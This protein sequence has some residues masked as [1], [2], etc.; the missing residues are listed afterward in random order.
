MSRWPHLQDRPEKVARI[1]LKS[2]DD[3]GK[4]GVDREFGH[5]RLNLEAALQPL[6]ARTLAT[7]GRVGDEAAA[8]PA[9]SLAT[10]SVFG[11]SLAA[12]LA[13][14]RAVVFDA[15]GRD[16]AIDPSAFAQPA[17]ADV[18]GHDLF[19]AFM[20]GTGS[21]S[22]PAVADTRSWRMALAAESDPHRHLPPGGFMIAGGAGPVQFGF[23][24][25][26][27]AF[28]FADALEG[29]ITA[30][31]PVTGFRD[32][33]HHMDLVGP[34]RAFGGRYELAGGRAAVG[35]VM[36]ER[37]NTPHA[38]VLAGGDDANGVELRGQFEPADGLTLG[39]RFGFVRE[40]GSVLGA[41]G[42]GAFAL[43][44]GESYY[45]GARLA[46]PL[47]GGFSLDLDLETGWITLAQDGDSLLESGRVR[48][49]TARLSLVGRDV[50]LARD[51]VAFGIPQPLR[52]ADGDLRVRLPVGRTTG[53]R[54][55]YDDAALSAE[56]EG[57]EL[58]LSFDYGAPLPQDIGR[59]QVVAVERL[60]PGH[61]PERTPE[62]LIFGKVTLVF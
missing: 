52:V 59:W 19:L 4:R 37:S 2:A 54:V 53:G 10:T 22:L 12:A 17:S 25:D 28:A 33:A 41:E 8:L 7:G 18:D 62:T 15:F 11:D 58:R 14:S 26:H 34:A 27:D 43:G 21:P 31:D 6:G 23:A 51:T 56:P 3:L 48:T 16:F 30:S 24:S 1:L 5:G 61:D 49:E 39:T 29:N 50:W 36:A 60:A 32:D 35:I 44:G 9:S 13:E 20:R 46:A 45:L 47:R 40:D 42:D 55:L 38:D 57:R